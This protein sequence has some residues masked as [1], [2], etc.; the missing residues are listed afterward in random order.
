MGAS[1]CCCLLRDL[2]RHA[3]SLG[4]AAVLW[5][6]EAAGSLFAQTCSSAPVWSH[7]VSLAPLGPQQ[8][9]VFNAAG[10]WVAQSC[11]I[12]S[13]VTQPLCLVGGT[14]PLGPS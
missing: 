4:T 5:A 12:F 9:N 6:F 8:S 2:P 14:S 7:W 1:G 10:G 13:Q 3:P 11:C